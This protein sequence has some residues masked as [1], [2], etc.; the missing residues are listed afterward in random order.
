MTNLKAGQILTWRYKE[1]NKQR[2]I[3][4]ER[5][6]QTVISETGAQRTLSVILVNKADLWIGRK[7]RVTAISNGQMPGDLIVSLQK[8]SKKTAAD[9]NTFKVE[10][11]RIMFD[12][13]HGNVS[14]GLREKRVPIT[15]T[16]QRKKRVVK[17]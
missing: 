1:D 6:A 14:T 3:S 9:Y 8:V 4:D 7:W 2:R 15:Q 5:I 13:V 17:Y 11:G 16:P 10:C 12:K